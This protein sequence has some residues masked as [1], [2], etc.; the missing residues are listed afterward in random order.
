MKIRRSIFGF[1]TVCAVFIALLVWFGRKP[2]ETSG[3]TG[4]EL[5]GSPGATA[6][7]ST[8]A[9]QQAIAPTHSNSP[10]T[11]ATS[12]RPPPI[13]L[14]KNKAD[15]M[16]E[17]LAEFNDEDVVLFGKV[18]DQF[19][20]SVTDATVVGSIQ[21]N[22][23]TRIGSDKISITTDSNGMFTVSGYKGKAL[24]IW[25]TKKGYVMAT[26]HTSFIY[27]HLWSEAE[28]YNPDPSDPAIIKMWKLQGAERLTSIDQRYKFH[29][30]DASVNIDVI[31]GKI[32]PAGGDIKITLS[33]APGEVSERTLQDWGVR[34]EAV[35]GG[36][37]ESIGDARFVYELPD[38]GY[39][40]SYGYIMSTNTHNWQGALQQMFY[41]QAR[42][43][44]VFS[45]LDFGVSI[46]REPDDYVWVELHGEF[47][48]NGSRNFEADA[49]A[50]AA[51]PQ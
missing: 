8:K 33:R 26:S 14:F 37:I 13:E 41:L 23:G 6:S 39:Q 16:K 10:V 2:L 25:V 47:N 19:G 32:V 49:R 44:Q 43:G 42:N 46:N 50:L 5:N 30:T 27:S 17:G 28:R 20:A 45:K 29:F 15:Q 7:V 1:V 21:V 4:D 24:G 9:R 35:D 3:P 22:N 34:I 18:I 12:S 36:L 48:P 38:G 11:T 31:T 40:A 51:R